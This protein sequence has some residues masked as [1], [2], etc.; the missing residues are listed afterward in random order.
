M[1]SIA[2]SPP[3]VL[4]YLFCF[5]WFLGRSDLFPLGSD[6]HAFKSLL[7]GHAGD[8]VLF[9]EV[10]PTRMPELKRE[11]LQRGSECDEDGS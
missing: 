9:E 7:S 6:G 8:V 4:L 3:L 2:L 5:C 1:V 10:M 11:I